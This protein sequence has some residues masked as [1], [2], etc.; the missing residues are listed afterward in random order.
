[1]PGEGRA[2]SEGVSVVACSEAAVGS[3]VPAAAAVAA[4]GYAGREIEA[5]WGDEEYC[6]DCPVV[7]F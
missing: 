7:C 5:V 6:T 4:A 2:L 3:K 1:M